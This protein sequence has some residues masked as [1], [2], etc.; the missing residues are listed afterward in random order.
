MTKSTAV[1]RIEV[2]RL[3]VPLVV[4]GGRFDIMEKK[5]LDE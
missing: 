5:L 4:V 1:T 2:K 3:M